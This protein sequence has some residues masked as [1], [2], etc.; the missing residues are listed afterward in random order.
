ML[1]LAGDSLGQGWWVVWPPYSAPDEGGFWAPVPDVLC[2]SLSQPA[3]GQRPY[4]PTLTGGLKHP[5]ELTYA[6]AWALKGGGKG[7]GVWAVADASNAPCR[8]LVVR[9]SG[10]P[11]FAGR[12]PAGT[13]VG[14]SLVVSSA[15]CRARKAVA[16]CPQHVVC[17]GEGGAVPQQL[18]FLS[19]GGLPCSP[20][21]G[22]LE[23]V[24]EVLA[25][26][27]GPGRRVGDPAVG[28]LSREEQGLRGLPFG[29]HLRS[30]GKRLGASGCA[31]TPVQQLVPYDACS[32][33]ECTGP[34]EVAE[35]EGSCGDRANRCNM[36]P[37]GALHM[38][39][40]ALSCQN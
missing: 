4:G 11:H 13:P 36:A 9:A 29:D 5:P 28:S 35:G 21:A 33:S 38:E 18:P 19:S 26:H 37:G 1:A 25:V 3:D 16:K 15:S 2:R 40:D 31:D 20:L 12:R 34:P 17:R 6:S 39:A 32:F 27:L 14:H 7:E 30:R 24:A 10:D 23:P 22:A 8:P